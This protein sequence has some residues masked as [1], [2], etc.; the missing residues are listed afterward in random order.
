M[1]LV[2]ES[3]LT[4]APARGVWEIAVL[5]VWSWRD[6]ALG[7]PAG[8]WDAGRRA[9]RTCR[10]VSGAGDAVPTFRRTVALRS[11]RPC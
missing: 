2:L 11:P 1:K 8:V 7:M 10:Q 5:G 4:V 3:C 6:A 9:S